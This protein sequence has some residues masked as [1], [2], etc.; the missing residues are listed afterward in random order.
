MHGASYNSGINI[1]TA[2]AVYYFT[3]C[4]RQR[5][6]FHT[7][8]LMQASARRPRHTGLV[9]ETRKKCSHFASCY[10]AVASHLF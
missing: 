6:M 4:C 3:L 5:R 8:W 9:P 7:T 1:I 2:F 10:G